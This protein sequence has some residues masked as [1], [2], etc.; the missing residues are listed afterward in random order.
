MAGGGTGQWP[1]GSARV[2]ASLLCRTVQGCWH[3]PLSQE[4]SEYLSV[5]VSLPV[6]LSLECFC[7]LSLFHS[8]VH[9]TNIEALLRPCWSFSLFSSCHRVSALNRLPVPDILLC[10][11]VSVFAVCGPLWSGLYGSP[12]LQASLPSH[13][14]IAFSVSGFLSF[15]LSH[16]LSPRGESSLCPSPLSSPS[17]SISVSRFRRVSRASPPLQINKPSPPPPPLSQGGGA[18]MWGALIFSH[19]T[20]AR[21]ARSRLPSW[22]DP[23]RRGAEAQDAGGVRGCQRARATPRA[24]SPTTHPSPGART[25]RRAHVVRPRLPG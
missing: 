14:N 8:Y 15:S 12:F 16:S 1:N 17:H 10:V 25:P 7:C 13:S 5:A 3:S 4:A 20:P 6:F 18:G 23:V 9:S 19:P 11:P 24:F 2:C 22:R 21:G